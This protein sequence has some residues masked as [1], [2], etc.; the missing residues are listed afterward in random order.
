MF[1]VEI[2]SNKKKYDYNTGD[3]FGDMKLVSKNQ[4]EFARMYEMDY[5][6]LNG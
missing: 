6:S 2:M 3:V 1:G 4:T 5:S